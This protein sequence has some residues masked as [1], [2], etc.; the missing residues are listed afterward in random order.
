MKKMIFRTALAAVL[1]M[2]SASTYAGEPVKYLDE[3]GQEKYVTDYKVLTGEENT[4]AGGWY[5]VES[6]VHEVNHSIRCEGNVHIVLMDK[7]VLL[8]IVW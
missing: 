2:L 3:Q 7:S 8:F 6:G 4:L 5:V 1:V